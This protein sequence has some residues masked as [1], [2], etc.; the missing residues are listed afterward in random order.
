MTIPARV[1][2]VTLAVHDFDRVYRF[3]Q[4]L[5]WPESIHN[6]EGYAAFLTGGAVLSLW[7][8]ENFKERSRA[9]VPDAFRGVMLAINVET[10]EMVD[11]VLKAAGEAG[12]S[13]TDKA[14][15][16]GWGG[17]TGGFADPEGNLWEVTWAPGT[18]FD[19]RGGLIFP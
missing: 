15:D 5:G 2:M 3:Y 8:L 18:S 1:S 14:V 19:E 17:R 11:A 9:A 13:I 7:P 6:G 16:T 12:A 4:A 10:P